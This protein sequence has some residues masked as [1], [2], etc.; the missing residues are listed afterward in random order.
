M[1]SGISAPSGASWNFSAPA[2]PPRSVSN[3]QAINRPV[4][5]DDAI[6]KVPFAFDFGL[7]A[8]GIPAAGDLSRFTY[9]CGVRFGYKRFTA[10]DGRLVAGV[11][12]DA[13]PGFE[14][15]FARSIRTGEFCLRTHA[16]L[17]YRAAVARFGELDDG[18]RRRVKQVLFTL[19]A[20]GWPARYGALP[21][22]H[23]VRREFALSLR[24][25]DALRERYEA[26]PFVSAPDRTLPDVI[27]CLSSEDV[28]FLRA[29]LGW[30]LKSSRR[31]P[32][33]PRP[34]VRTIRN[35]ARVK[36]PVADRPRSPY[37]RR[38]VPRDR[39]R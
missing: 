23:S 11:W 39:Q 22:F 26:V 3:G 30:P 34:I 14:P 29:R 2:P 37:N 20:D 28:H 8:V 25:L 15:Y 36:E 33:P 24:D 1:T 12:D 7:G 32:R 6:L 35:A 38:S 13:R 10:A 31:A 27:P 5:L 4:K 21:L 18:H 9:K 16:E 17:P 19:P